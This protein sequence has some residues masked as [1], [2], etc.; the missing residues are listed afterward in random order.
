MCY[1]VINHSLCCI[2][3]KRSFV[4]PLEYN[5]R[6][7]WTSGPTKVYK[8]K[9]T[10]ECTTI[11]VNG[12]YLASPC[13][14]CWPFVLSCCWLFCLSKSFWLCHIAWYL[15]LSAVMLPL[16]GFIRLFVWFL[17]VHFCNPFCGIRSFS[18]VS[19]CFFFSVT[20][21]LPHLFFLTLLTTPAYSI[22]CWSDYSAI[23]LSLFNVLIHKEVIE[24]KFKPI[25]PLNLNMVWS[26]LF[27]FGSDLYSSIYI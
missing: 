13:L 10:V 27:L 7:L 22:M 23:P 19:N 24:L 12:T 25:F 21:W 14:T 11:F 2:D 17:S 6:K 18:I 8:V 26:F 9:V 1:A 4:R 20:G 16:F 3:C 5:N 15:T